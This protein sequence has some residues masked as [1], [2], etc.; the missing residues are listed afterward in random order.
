MINWQRNPICGIGHEILLQP[1]PK[2]LLH[3][4]QGINILQTPV[5]L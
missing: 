1:E 4:T 2:E 3:V 5:F